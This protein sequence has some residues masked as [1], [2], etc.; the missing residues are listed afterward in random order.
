MY[1]NKC[2]GSLFNFR[3]LTKF[4]P[5]SAVHFLLN[6]HN[7]LSFFF[8]LGGGGGGV[9]I[10]GWVLINFLGN[11]DGHLFQVGTPVLI[12]GWPCI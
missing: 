4:S 3:T 2:S 12:H 7:I 11:Q 6:I 10:L 1:L 9:F 5:F 8:F